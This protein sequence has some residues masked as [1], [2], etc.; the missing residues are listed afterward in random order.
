MPELAP[1]LF[2][3]CAYVIGTIPSGLIV[4][5]LAGLGDIRRVGSGNIGATNM[6][7]AGNKKLG[8]ITLLLDATKAIT[9]IMLCHYNQF[10][11]SI[12]GL[13]LIGLVTILGHCFPVWLQFK[14]GKGVATGLGLIGT[15]HCLIDPLHWWLIAIFAVS[16]IGVYKLTRIVSVASLVTFSI[17][18]VFTYLWY[19]VWLAPLAVTMLIVLRHHANIERLLKGE[20]YGF[21]PST[22]A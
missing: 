21:R 18:P 7:R 14:G 17:L 20:E 12:T 10:F 15:V 1:T 4:G 11:T 13:Y 16:W 9:V 3:L 19:G 8:A 6:V 22:N 2:I 5:K